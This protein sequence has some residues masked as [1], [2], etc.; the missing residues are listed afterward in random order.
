M[1]KNV[2]RFQPG[3]FMYYVG[4]WSYWPRNSKGIVWISLKCLYLMY[5]IYVPSSSSCLFYD[6][7]CPCMHVRQ[8][9]HLSAITHR[10]ILW[11]LHTN[12]HIH[13]H[14]YTHRHTHTHTNTHTHTQTLCAKLIC[15]LVIHWLMKYYPHQIMFLC[16]VGHS[17][18]P[19][20]GL[21]IIPKF[22]S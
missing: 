3:C 16:M 14:T 20:Y 7:W 19:T 2:L 10:N 22:D 13:T 9:I 18:N 1:L 6:N 17:Y 21:C 5:A 8:V 4:E 15:K 12:T 11:C